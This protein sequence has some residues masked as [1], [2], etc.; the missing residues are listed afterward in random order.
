MKE[1]GFVYILR[2]QKDG[3]RY[4]GST[5]NVGRR[6]SQHNSGKVQSTKYR[7]PFIIEAALEYATLQEGRAWEKKFKSSSGAL[8]RALMQQATT[9]NFNNRG[10]VHR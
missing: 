5:N 1:K 9:A 4:I 10:V 6:L 7:R 2:S 3:R 8:S